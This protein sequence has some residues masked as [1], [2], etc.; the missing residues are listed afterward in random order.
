MTGFTLDN[1]ILNDEYQFKRKIGC[2][3]Y[4]L[5]Y[6]IE[7]LPTGKLMAAKILLKNPPMSHL[8][9]DNKIAIQHQLYSYFNEHPNLTV[10]ELDLFQ[11]KSSVGNCPFLRE[12]SLHL[13]VHDH[14]NVVTIHK[15]FNTP[16]AVVIC[17]DYFP[18]GDLFHNIINNHLFLSI[19]NSI[20]RSRLMKNVMLQLINVINYCH[21]HSIYHCDLKPENIMINYNHHYRRPKHSTS[22]IDYN[23]CHI[24]L[25]DFG[26]AM[27]SNLICCNACR[28]SSFYMAPERIINYNVNTTI[29]KYVDL[30]QYKSVDIN[31]TTVTK[32]NS[33]YFPTLQGDIWSLGVLFINIACARNP[34]PVASIAED[35]YVFRD[36]SLNNNKSVLKQILPI[37]N[38]FNRLLDKIFQ[39]DPNQRISLPELYH[40]IT[41]VD[42]F[43]DVNQLN[44]PPDSD[45]EDFK[46]ASTLDTPENSLMETCLNKTKKFNCPHHNY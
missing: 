1:H 21:K 13:Q 26:L 32:S 41:V 16:I 2:G 45:N 33:T 19:S 28:G 3:T 38:Q 11:L 14:P 30:N 40:E 42:F 36:Y 24:V 18:Q 43:N 31:H 5:I 29:Q 8:T 20:Q 7:H 34:W 39:L 6:L 23:E 15:V 12:I 37:S 9:E 4:G 27:N 22:I 35:S 10:P 25:I 44:T 17:M 46:F